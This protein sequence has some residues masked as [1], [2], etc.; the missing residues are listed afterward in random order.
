MN[1]ETTDTGAQELPIIRVPPILV[2]VP[3]QASGEVSGIR[4]WNSVVLMV[5]LPYDVSD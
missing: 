2:L 5:K 3:I 1:G 4:Y